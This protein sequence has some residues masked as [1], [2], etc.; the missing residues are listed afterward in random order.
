MPASLDQKLRDVIE[1]HLTCSPISP[2]L[3]SRDRREWLAPNVD[4]T[5][6]FL[7][8]LKS[9][10]VKKKKSIA[11]LELRV[12]FR[13]SRVTKG[14]GSKDRENKFVTECLINAELIPPFDKKGYS[15]FESETW[16]SVLNNPI[17]EP[18][19]YFKEGPQ[20]I[21]GNDIKKN[22]VE[23]N[24]ETR[25]KKLN[26]IA[27]RAERQPRGKRKGGFPAALLEPCEMAALKRIEKA[28]RSARR[29]DKPYKSPFTD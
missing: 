6:A 13:Y 15:Q 26:F 9:A 7:K 24:D 22:D 10:E 16:K 21:K 11:I 23:G 28:E 12:L 14:R 3:A 18:L 29:T 2:P 1:R 20:D 25:L 27:T 19:Q 8:F 5:I 17:S 4:R